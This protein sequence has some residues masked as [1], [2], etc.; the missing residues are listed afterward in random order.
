MGTPRAAIGSSSQRTPEKLEESARCAD[1]PVM[2]H[3]QPVREPAPRPRPGRLLGD[4]LV[5]LGF[6][7]RE[8][9]E[10]IVVEARSLA[11]PMGQVLLQHGLIDPDQ[12]AIAVAERFGLQYASLETL[13][14]DRAAMRLVTPTVARRV[15]AV[16][17]GF[18]DA[19]TLLVAMPNPANV[20][21]IDDLAMITGLHIEPIVVSREDLDALLA[22]LNRVD[23]IDEE[24][25]H[26][27]EQEEEAAEAASEA[28]ADDSPTVRLVRSI[29]ALAIEQGASDLHFDP[30]DDHLKVRFR[31]DGIMSEATRIPARQAPRVISRIKIL[32]Q[33]D[34]SERRLPQDGRMSLTFD[35]RRIDIRVATVP[36]VDGESCVMRLLDPGRRPLS[37][38]ELGMNDADRARVERAL[39]SSRGAVLATGPTGSGKTTTLYAGLAA[40][41]SAEKTVM[42]IEDP[43][44]YRVAGVKQMQVSERTGLT[45]ANGL[46]TIVRSDPDIIMVGEIRDFESARIT[47]EAGLTGHLV[48]STLHTNDAPGAVTRLVDI[49]VE[50]YLVASSI[51]CVIAQRLAR[52]LCA[53]CKRPVLM[54]AIEVGGGNS[55]EIEVFEP[56]GCKRCRDTGYKG[57]LG[58]F[59]VMRMTD[60]IRTLIVARAAAA[61]IARAA[62]SEGMH[63]IVQDG[64]AKVR[65]GE[66]TLTE[67]ARVTT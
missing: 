57:R 14:P 66:T 61:E 63:T 2:Q 17:V 31:V 5:S 51:G 23:Q 50:P 41:N 35:D 25:A 30:A 10:E 60:T 40:V 65:A 4:V 28:L 26:H 59:E 43:V 11:R 18:K 62:A 38:A 44:E 56:G 12:L 34:I 3:E 48:L 55:G 54:P 22:R 15:H 9:I 24:P 21:A 67:V 47:I 33:L 16:P 39:T 53:H 13:V 46:R 45:F 37:F 64:L 29:I 58:L 42:T 20:I 8:T 36:L 27:D 19:D 49:G 32:S 1:T 6:C 52:R 7:T